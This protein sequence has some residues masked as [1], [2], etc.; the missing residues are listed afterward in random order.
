MK[1]FHCGNILSCCCL[2]KCTSN[3]TLLLVLLIYF[4]YVD[5]QPALHIPKELPAKAMVI[6]KRI[7]SY[8]DR[9]QLALKV[10]SQYIAIE[11]MGY[12]VGHIYQQAWRYMMINYGY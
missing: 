4:V 10:S 6:K 9:T 5:L 11:K 7:P 8:Y 2:L 12:L 1:I 3:I